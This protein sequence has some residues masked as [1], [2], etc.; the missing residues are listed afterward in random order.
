MSREQSYQAIIIKKQPYA[1]A[2]EI[3]TFLTPEGKLRGLAKSVKLISSK[4][5]Q[6]LQPVFLNQ[7]TLAGS[8]LPKIISAQ[9][10]NAYKNILSNPERV[11]I[12]YVMA[13]LLNKALADEQ[14]N[15]ALFELVT[16]YLKFLDAPYI[17]EQLLADSLSKFKIELM[18]DLGLRIHIPSE[19]SELWFSASK[20]GFY[21]GTQSADTRAVTPNDWQAFNQLKQTSFV[22]LANLSLP[23]HHLNELINEFI[24]YQL[25][26][27]IKAERFL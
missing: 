27:E 12:W 1:E 23:P 16:E 11:Q 21:S 25:E 3:I 5:Q 10:I 14:K 24:E 19:S 8:G 9:T 22:D 6:A 15:E 20:G 13:E 26:R 18:D 4:L 7:I 17:S 2:D